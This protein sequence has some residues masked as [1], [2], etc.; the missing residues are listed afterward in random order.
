MRCL[1]P[2]TCT[3]ETTASRGDVREPG[4]NVRLHLCSSCVSKVVQETKKPRLQEQIAADS[5]L[6]SRLVKAHPHGQFGAQQHVAS[7]VGMHCVNMR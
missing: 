4:C 3:T 2:T 6:R 5:G 1:A 7:V